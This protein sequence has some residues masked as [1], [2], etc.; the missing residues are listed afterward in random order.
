[1]ANL[2]QQ[3][4]ERL[5]GIAEN[6]FSALLYIFYDKTVCVFLR[7]CLFLSFSHVRSFLLFNLFALNFM[8]NFILFLIFYSF[9]LYVK[10]SSQYFDIQSRFFIIFKKYCLFVCFFSCSVNGTSVKKKEKLQL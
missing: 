3:S 10:S 9:S 7:C 1:M 4:K 2:R 6:Y 8:V 5:P